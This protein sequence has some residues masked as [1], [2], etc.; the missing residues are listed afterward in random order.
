[1]VERKRLPRAARSPRL[2]G[3]NVFR[4]TVTVP[5]LIGL[6]LV[7][8]GPLPAGSAGAAG[9]ATGNGATSYQLLR[10]DPCLTDPAMTCDSTLAGGHVPHL[11]YVPL[12][13]PAQPKLAVFFPGTGARPSYYT[14][15]AETLAARGWFVID[16]R[17]TTTVATEDA[18]P[19]S[20]EKTD[21]ECYRQFRSESIFGQNVADPTGHAYNYV[22]TSVDKVN[23]VMNRLLKLVG[24]LR[25]HPTLGGTG[26]TQFLAVRNGTCS[27]YNTTYGACNLDW[28]RLALGGHSQGAGVALYLA[29]FYKVA[30]VAMLS[31]PEDAYV[32]P[33]RTV[34]AP[35]IA[36]GRFATPVGDIYGFTQVNDPFYQR[37]TAAWAALGL[38]GPLAHYT[39]NHPLVGGHRIVTSIAPACPLLG[40]VLAAHSAT[41]VVG[42]VD[43]P[44]YAAVWSAMFGPP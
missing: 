28:S 29:K 30:R 5:M 31:G 24:Y 38:P 39:S 35:W 41:S 15:V 42:C 8:A 25:A 43:L 16:L 27:S 3:L 14:P 17:Y 11:V 10:I 18:C 26:W 4:I 2:A 6:F 22:G 44:A 40:A 12:H 21:P 36:E 13:P 37:Q 7:G 33:T 19:N 20:G 32:L 34:A 1:M 23:S 9:S